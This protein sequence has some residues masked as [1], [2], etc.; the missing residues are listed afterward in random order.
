MRESKMTHKMATILLVAMLAV[1]V[2]PTVAYAEADTS[3]Q[4]RVLTAQ[5]LE[6]SSQSV[7]P[8]S[9]TKSFKVADSAASR[10]AENRK[11]HAAYKKKLW[12]LR[13]SQGTTDP[14]MSAFVDLTGDGVD[15]MVVLWWP[16]VYTYRSGKAVRVEKG[17][18]GSDALYRAYKKAHVIVKG[19]GDTMGG[20]SRVYKRWNGK[21]FVTVASLYTPSS[22]GIAYGNQPSYWT[23]ADGYTTKAR[24]KAYV[25]K[26]IGADKAS[27]IKYRKNW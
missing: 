18:V 10:K 14:P 16:S 20:V 27:R 11:A 2:V 12:Q 23:K 3:L 22:T 1:S 17:F 19:R 7:R 15:E 26:L 4:S 5:T 25:K 13:K 24:A 8:K 21:K 9:V 6:M